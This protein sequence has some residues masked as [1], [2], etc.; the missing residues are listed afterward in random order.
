MNMRL[1]TYE[2]VYILQPNLTE[3]LNINIIQK[4]KNLISWNGGK[5]IHI[6]HRGRRHLSYNI[7]KHYDGTYIQVN[8]EGTEKLLQILRKSIKFDSHILRHFFKKNSS[9]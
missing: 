2:M 7:N 3:E 6:Q 8:F 1:N 5:K 4:Y 9:K